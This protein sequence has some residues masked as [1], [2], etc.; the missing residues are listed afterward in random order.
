V[1]GPGER[2]ALG[3]RL[4][5]ARQRPLGAA[6]DGNGGD[7]GGAGAVAPGEPYGAAVD[8]HGGALGAPARLLGGETALDAAGVGRHDD[9]LAVELGHEPGRQAGVGRFGTVRAAG[10]A[11]RVAAAAGRGVGRGR[12]GRGDRA[13]EGEGSQGGHRRNRAPPFPVSPPPPQPHG[14]ST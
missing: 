11:L 9:D 1:S 7:V 3:A 4:A 8:A 10:R 6:G 2:E 13:E 5:G 14:R 12:P